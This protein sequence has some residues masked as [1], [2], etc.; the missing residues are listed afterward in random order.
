[1]LK[2]FRDDRIGTSVEDAAVAEAAS[3]VD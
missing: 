2:E 3:I 1:L